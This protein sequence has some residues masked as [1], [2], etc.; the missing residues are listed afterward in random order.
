MDF[1]D[2][3]SSSLALPVQRRRL[4][5]ETNNMTPLATY[6]VQAVICMAYACHERPLAGDERL[7]V[8]APPCASPKRLKC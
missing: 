1:A 7:G 2:D 6:T 8:S 5:T 3:G 4:V